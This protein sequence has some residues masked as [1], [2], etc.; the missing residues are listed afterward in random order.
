LIQAS[1]VK[2]GEMVFIET[3]VSTIIT[4]D[5]IVSSNT[6]QDTHLYG[7]GSAEDG[8]WRDKDGKQAPQAIGKDPGRFSWAK[9][10]VGAVQRVRGVGGF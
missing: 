3:R 9:G 10:V 8:L 5:S 6:I 4:I 1:F 2:L 7:M